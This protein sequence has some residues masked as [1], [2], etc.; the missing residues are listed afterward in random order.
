MLIEQSCGADIRC[1]DFSDVLSDIAR[2]SVSLILTDPPYS[3]EHLELWERLSE[4]AADK[5][6]PGGF[7][8]AYSGQFYLPLVI[9]ALCNHLQY[10][11]TISLIGRGPKTQV[12]ARRVNSNWKPI[13]VFCKPPYQPSIWMEDVIHGE[14]PEKDHHDWQQSTSEAIRLIESFSVPG[15]LVVDPFIGSGTNGV[16]ALSLGRDFIGCDKD[17]IA[18]RTAMG[19][20]ENEMQTDGNGTHPTQISDSTVP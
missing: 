12:H 18:V 9:S 10:I 2:G 14:G 5:L 16:A 13:M 6:R 15:D 1:G 3:K 19:R 17:P 20:V 8:V 11:W 7:L 4:F